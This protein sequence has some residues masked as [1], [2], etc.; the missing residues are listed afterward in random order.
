[1]TGH[2]MPRNALA[3]GAVQHGQA[4]FV[5]ILLEAFNGYSDI[6]LGLNWTLSKTLVIVGLGYIASSEN[7]TID[8]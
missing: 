4:G 3:V 2:I 1:M 6:E 8:T 7:G 5:V